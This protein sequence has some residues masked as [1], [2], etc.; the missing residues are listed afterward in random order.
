MLNLTQ[1]RRNAWLNRLQSLLLMG[2]MAGFLAM[3]GHLVWGEDGLFTLLILSVVLMIVNPVVSPWLVLRLYRARPLHPME[4][5]ALYEMLAEL[6]RRAELPVVPTLCYVPSDMVNAFTVGGRRDAVI[7]ITDGLLRALNWREIAGV[8]AHEV[9]HIRNDDLRVMGLADLMSRLTNLLSLF[10]QLL[11]LVHL[12]QVFWGNQVQVN[13]WALAL[14]IFAPHIALLVQLGLSRTR[15]FHAD[16]NAVSLTGDPEGLASAL[17]KIEYR[18]RRLLDLLLPGLHVPEP[19]W[20]RSHPPT[21]ERIRRLLA[22]T[23][24]PVRSPVWVV[25]Q[26]VWERRTIRSPRYHWGGL[27]Y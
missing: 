6:A 11:V 8:L 9:S 14:L 1:W 4:I 19:S 22:L 3:L 12:P 20:L 27:W 16:L 26:P 25:G 10:G 13:W 2:F 5:P 23:E 7:G 18:S 17:A 15:E 24:S 21:E